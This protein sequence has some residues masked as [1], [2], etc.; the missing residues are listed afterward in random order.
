ME[1]PAR[2]LSADED[3]RLRQEIL[4]WKASCHAILQDAPTVRYTGNDHVK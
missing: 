1:M 2:S 3:A 4:T